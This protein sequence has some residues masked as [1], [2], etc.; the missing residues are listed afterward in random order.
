MSAVHSHA[1]HVFARVIPAQS[2]D[3]R[4]RN[5]QHRYVTDRHFFSFFTPV[6]CCPSPPDNA[7]SD[8]ALSI[9]LTGIDLIGNEEIVDKYRF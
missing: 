2:T 9:I 5:A 4:R 6:S 7:M 8:V 1:R 3:Y